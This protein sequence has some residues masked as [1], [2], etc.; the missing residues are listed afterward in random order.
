MQRPL[1][2]GAQGRRLRLHPRELRERRASDEHVHLRP[3]ERRR[4]KTEASQGPMDSTC[5][6]F[7]RMLMQERVGSIFMLC[8]TVEDGHRKCAQYWPRDVGD[9]IVF[10]GRRRRRRGEEGADVAVTNTGMDTRDPQNHITTL[11]CCTKT[12]KMVTKH[13]HWKCWP[14]K[15]IPRSVM[16]PFRLL[17]RSRH[18][19]SGGTRRRRRVRIDPQSSI[20]L[21][22][23]DALAPSSPSSSRCSSSSLRRR[24][25]SSRW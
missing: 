4:E 8:E 10:G 20:A 22:E 16:A 9:T 18:T 13:F 17:R 21:R 12:E 7:W 23:L 1:P 6:E 15:S 5:V 24:S 11:E 19:V 14:D 2:R 25:R 3:G